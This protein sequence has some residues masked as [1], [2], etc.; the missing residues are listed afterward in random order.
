MAYKDNSYVLHCRGGLSVWEKATVPHNP[1]PFSEG[2]CQEVG[3]ETTICQS[4]ETFDLGL[5]LPRQSAGTRATGRS[6]HQLVMTTSASV[7]AKS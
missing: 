7:I 2:L 1:W 5:H 6:H 3:K 4:F